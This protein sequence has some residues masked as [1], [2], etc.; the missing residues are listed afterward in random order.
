[1]NKKLLVLAPFPNESNIKDGMISRVHSIDQ[2]FQNV[3]RTYLF[4]SL[5]YNWVKYIEYQDNV[6]IYNL[7]IIRHFFRI[8]KIVLS[9]DTIYVHS[10]HMIK[11]IWYL[12]FILKPREIVLD[13]HGA[14]PEEEKFF[15][16]RKIILL[17][18][19]MVERIVF[20]HVKKVICVTYS[21]RDHFNIKY[22]KYKGNY[23]VYSILPINIKTEQSQNLIK[24][25]D[26][27]IILYSGGISPWQ[28]VDYMLQII[29]K[30]QAPNILYII[31]TGH[32]TEFKEIIS[33]YHISEQNLKLDS[34]N[35]N[36]LSKYYE[37]TDY[38][39]ILRDDNPVNNVANPTKMV[40]YLYYGIIPIVLTPNIGDYA[41]RGMEYISVDKF[42]TNIIKPLV[43]SQKNKNIIND[44]I[45]E[46]KEINILD[47][48]NK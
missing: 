29:E 22:P 8:C 39:F 5:R 18:Y 2:F 15:K 25:D 32:V 31:L 19:T 36:E 28:K 11:H 30:N 3:E 45:T 1:M 47:I 46:N 23:Y 35:P 24:S 12:M 4:V 6:H 10:I 9:A 17:F 27:I 14:V 7:N 44:L 26:K 21:M 41:K 40:E 37:L 20:S 48:L 13:A 33:K 34:V 42:D 16:N 38:G 43:R